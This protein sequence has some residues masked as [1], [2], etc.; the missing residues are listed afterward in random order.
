MYRKVTCICTH[1]ATTTTTIRSSADYLVTD[2][3]FQTTFSIEKSPSRQN[4]PTETHVATSEESSNQSIFH[5]GA[6][7]SAGIWCVKAL[8]L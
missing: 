3:S 5:L 8:R 4:L 6:F 1:A 2:L 7:K